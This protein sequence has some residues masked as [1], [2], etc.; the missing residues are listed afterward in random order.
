MSSQSSQNPGSG[1][2]PDLERCDGC[3]KLRLVCGCVWYRARR[4]PAPVVVLPAKPARR[5]FRLHPLIGKRRRPKQKSLS[6]SERR[7]RIWLVAYPWMFE[8]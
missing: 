4:A 6:G 3:G 8:D 1:P 7:H 2:D 5:K